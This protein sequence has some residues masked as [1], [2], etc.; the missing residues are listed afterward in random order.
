[1]HNFESRDPLEVA[2]QDLAG[3]LSSDTEEWY[4]GTIGRAEDGDGAI[5]IF[6]HEPGNFA[7]IASH[8]VHFSFSAYQDAVSW[9]S[10]AS[11]LIYGENARTAEDVQNILKKKITT[12]RPSRVL[13]V[14]YS[15]G[16]VP[17][18]IKVE[19]EYDAFRF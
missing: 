5:I 1:M 12:A 7:G 14:Q 3:K 11:V 10:Q 17:E 13:S 8:S 15:K 6:F 18:T 2:A 9:L 4:I 16:P 19:V